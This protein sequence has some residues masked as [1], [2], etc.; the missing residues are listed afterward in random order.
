LRG[1]GKT[2]VW[3]AAVALWL[4]S[5]GVGETHGP[6]VLPTPTWD[7]TYHEPRLALPEVTA[8]A[9]GEPFAQVALNRNRFTAGQTLAIGFTVR[10]PGPAAQLFIGAV[11]PDGH[12]LAFFSASGGIAG[13]G[14]L[15]NPA[16]F[17]RTRAVPGGTT[18]VDSGFLEFVFPESGIPAG[19]YT[20]FVALASQGAFADGRMDPGDILALDL[21][22]L[23]FGP[24]PGGGFLSRPFAGEFLISNYF[25]HFYPQEFVDANGVSIAFWGEPVASFDGH[26]GYDHAMPEGTPLL[27]A[28]DGVVRLAGETQAFFCP[29]LNATVRN[30][31]VDIVHTRP[32]GQQ[33][34]VSYQHLSQVAVSVNE[35]VTAGQLI[36]LSGSTGCS[37]GPHLH[38]AVYRV[39][40]VRNRY[41]I[42]DPYGWEGDQPDPWEQHPDGT[43]S[44]WLWTDAAAPAPLAGFFIGPNPYG[45]STAPV[46]ITGWAWA[47]PDDLHNPGNEFVEVALDTRYSG[48]P[49]R[50]L[51]GFTL[52]NNGGDV[53]AFP[54]G[55]VLH[56][57]RPVRVYSGPGVDTDTALHWGR[58]AGVWN[59]TRDCVRLVYPAG[60][61]YYF[62]NAPGACQSAP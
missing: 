32:S 50:D 40:T 53:Y 26:E 5:A 14:D 56:G 8:R 13:T 58:P 48:G 19:A 43:F 33:F 52:R 21:K 44:E 4:A 24:P 38:F 2:W 34:L 39:D 27:A 29:P 59:N 6:R 51:T 3:L 35:T 41:V 1:Q 61:Y 54:A 18:L 9:N 47:G 16:G 60:G 28:A 17:M 62:V 22:T 15:A 10:N 42:T 23:E 12:S 7:P 36:G 25:D 46:A 11:L 45:G 30:V 57:D 37:T 55:F 31:A 20:I 49:T